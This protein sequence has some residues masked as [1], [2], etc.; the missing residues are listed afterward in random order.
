MLVVL[1]VQILKLDSLVSAK[2]IIV[3]GIRDHET[4]TLLYMLVVFCSDYEEKCSLS[5][6]FGDVA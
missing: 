6:V 3:L 2:T 1:S 5:F 4:T